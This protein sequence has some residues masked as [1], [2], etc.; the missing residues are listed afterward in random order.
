MSKQKK[1][2]N[3]TNRLPIAIIKHAQGNRL[4][5]PMDAI[6]GSVATITFEGMEETTITLNWEIKGQ[7]EPRFLPI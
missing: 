5:D 2:G 4:L 7:D 1:P 6:E 3:G